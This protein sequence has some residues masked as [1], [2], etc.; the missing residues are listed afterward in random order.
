MFDFVSL[1][2]WPCYSLMQSLQRF[3]LGI[4]GGTLFGK[5]L[6]SPLSTCF[7]TTRDI[8]FCMLLLNPLRLI[9]DLH[10]AQLEISPIPIQNPLS[11][12]FV[13]FHYC[14]WTKL[15]NYLFHWYQGR[16]KKQI[17]SSDC[18]LGYTCKTGLVG[19][20]SLSSHS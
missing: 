5:S 7:P 19:R 12:F 17:W 2:P 3:R 10:T 16:R 6:P 4:F 9:F 1:C 13:G 15:L 8:L 20:L 14:S 18:F 11:R